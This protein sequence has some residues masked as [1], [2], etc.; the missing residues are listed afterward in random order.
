MG[1]AIALGVADT[2]W[3]VRGSSGLKMMRR[4]KTMRRRRRMMRT[5][6]RKKVKTKMQGEKLEQTGVVCAPFYWRCHL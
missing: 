5:R 4:R 1:L 6:M 3:T 2:E